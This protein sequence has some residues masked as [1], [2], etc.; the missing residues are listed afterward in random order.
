MSP[1]DLATAL[2]GFVSGYLI[3]VTIRAGILSARDRHRRRT[4]VPR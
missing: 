2:V 3:A 1:P 4:D